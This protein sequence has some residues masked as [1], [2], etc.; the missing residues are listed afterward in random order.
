MPFNPQIPRDV[1]EDLLD[2]ALATIRS[3]ILDKNEAYGD[4]ALNPVR[5]FSKADTAEQLRARIDDKLSRIIRGDPDAFF[6]SPTDDLTGYFVLLEM[7][8]EAKRRG[9]VS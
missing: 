9:L 3:R 1:F 4:S 6:E 5:I 8:S 7:H 2:D